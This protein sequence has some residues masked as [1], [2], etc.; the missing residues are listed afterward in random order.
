MSKKS[1]ES[2]TGSS[3]TT[4]YEYSSTTLR[5]FLPLWRKWR[6]ITWLTWGRYGRSVYTHAFL[7][8]IQRAIGTRTGL[9][10]RRVH[11]LE[12]IMSVYVRLKQAGCKN[13]WRKVNLPVW[14]PWWSVTIIQQ[15]WRQTV[16]IFYLFHWIQAKQYL[17]KAK[18]YMWVLYMCKSFVQLIGE[19]AMLL[20]VVELYIFSYVRKRKIYSKWKILGKKKYFLIFYTHEVSL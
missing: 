17:W 11:E 15:L 6:H 10:R 14:S 3:N 4:G 9:P 5:P 16:K 20:T 13:N 2:K 18:V 7:L 12:V 8:I 19:V 1:Q